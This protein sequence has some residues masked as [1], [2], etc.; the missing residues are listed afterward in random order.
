[1]EKEK[2][3]VKM[4][5][6]YQEAVAYMEALLDSLKS[7]KIVVQADDDF[8]TLT[9]AENVNIKVEAKVKKG[10]HKF[11]FELNWSEASSADL[12]ISDKEPTTPMPPAEKVVAVKKDAQTVAPKKTAE[13]PVTKPRPKKTAPKK[14][15]S[16]KKATAKKTTVK[17]TT[18]KKKTTTAKKTTS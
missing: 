9:P 15:A 12:T 5:L 8:V 6:S 2:I 18:P 11:G 14:K 3:G 17:K 7:R 16:V 1:M 10:K 4:T 13:S